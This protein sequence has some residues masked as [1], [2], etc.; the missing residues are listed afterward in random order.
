MRQLRH[1]TVLD[2]EEPTGYRHL[3]DDA[4]H[5]AGI[6]E[7]RN[8]LSVQEA[9]ILRYILNTNKVLKKLTV[10]RASPSAMRAAFE[11]VHGSCL[12]ELTLVLI[13]C[14]GQDFSINWLEAFRNLRFLSLA[15]DHVRETFATSI[16]NYLRENT[17]LIEF[18]LLSGNIGDDGAKVLAKSMR[19]NKTLKRITLQQQA[20]TSDSLVAFAEALV[21][22]STLQMVEV[23]AVNFEE[24]RVSCLVEQGTY[25]GVFKRMHVVWSE[26]LLPHLT[27]LLRHDNHCDKVSVSLTAAVNEDVLREFFKAVAASKTVRSLQ[28]CWTDKTFDA[29]ADGIAYVLRQTT[30]VKEI[31]NLMNVCEE[32]D[33]QLVRVLD[34]L[35]ENLSVTSFTMFADCVTQKIAKSL[36]DLLTANRTLK[37]LNICENDKI[38]PETVKIIVGGLR[39][40][41]T[42]TT[43]KVAWEFDEEVGLKEIE[44]LLERNALVSSATTLLPSQRHFEVCVRDDDTAKGRRERTSFATLQLKNT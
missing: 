5:Q 44:L 38:S 39:R 4:V 15:C 21:A 34:A 17:S 41:Y 18:T 7:Y 29:L 36:C 14:K 3:I 43:L 6:L 22:N 13:D 20:L 25:A 32:C 42:V 11:D 23:S 8:G 37:E 33:S 28:F 24:E 35:K 19:A 40:N 2:D 9:C 27:S 12:E 10:R 16:A 1:S 31:R 30:S 26:N